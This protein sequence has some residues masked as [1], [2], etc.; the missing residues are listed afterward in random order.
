M[1]DNSPP[2]DETFEVQV[3]EMHGE[4]VEH[5]LTTYLSADGSDSSKLAVM[6]AATRAVRSFMDA[7]MMMLQAGKAEKEE[8]G[9]ELNMVFR[10]LSE[11]LSRKAVT[12]H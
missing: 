10:I 1:S 3:N 6:F 5:L 7:R 12:K 8:V 4:I 9:R 2:E 11:E